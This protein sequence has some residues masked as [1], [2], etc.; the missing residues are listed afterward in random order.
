[1]THVN[2]ALT[3]TPVLSDFSIVVTAERLLPTRNDSLVE[4]RVSSDSPLVHIPLFAAT[5]SVGNVQVRLSHFQVSCL[6]EE[7]LR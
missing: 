2:H 1:M 5:V 3:A 6:R 7:V 4:K